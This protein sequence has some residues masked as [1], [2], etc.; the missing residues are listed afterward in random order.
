MK[1]QAKAWKRWFSVACNHGNL[2]DAEAIAAILKFKA[3]WKPDMTIHHG[4][5]V[6]F[7]CLRGGADG[8][9]DEGVSLF[10]D[11]NA[12][13]RF[14][15]Q[16]EPNVVCLGNH[17]DRAYRLRQSARSKIAYAAAR[18]VTDYETLVKDKLKAKLIPYDLETGWVALGDTLFG[19]GYMFNQLAIRDHAEAIGKCVIGH[20]HRV[21]QERGRHISSPT[22]YCVGFLGDKSKFSY[23][24]T[25]R[26]KFA[27]SQGFG[28]GEYNEQHCIVRLEQ[29]SPCGW[30][31]PL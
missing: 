20:L 3:I 7:T 4:D 8:S 15:E 11:F 30:R 24:K 6:D 13:T 31:L 1:R 5:S 25:N 16:L 18:L 17:C 28:W 23:A 2:G 9:P 21:G 26:Q 14:L 10:D 19:H 27:W 22:A 12:G 29:K